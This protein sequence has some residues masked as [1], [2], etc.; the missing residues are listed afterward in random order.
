MSGGAKP[1]NTNGRKHGH[2][3]IGNTLA[4]TP[5]YQSWRCMKE[6]C[7][8]DRHPWYDRYGGRGITVCDRWL[9]Y[10]TGFAN[11]LA[12]MGPRPSANHSIDRH[13]NPNGNYEPS[14]CRW[15]DKSQQF[16]A[17]ERPFGRKRNGHEQR[18]RERA[19]AA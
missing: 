13:P 3:S 9:G 7:Y 16:A 1:G 15:A 10:G 18:I 4:R 19:E 2:T 8:Y 11:F 12:D 17:I 5:T 6:R 14:N